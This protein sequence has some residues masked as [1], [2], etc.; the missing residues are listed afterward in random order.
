[1]K[2]NTKEF[3]IGVIIVAVLIVGGAV[4]IRDNGEISNQ[5]TGDFNIVDQATQGLTNEGLQ[6]ETTT[7]GTGVAAI[8]GDTVLVHYTGKL[9]DG[10]VFDSSVENGRSPI[11]FTLGQNKVIKG[12]EQGIVGMKVGEKRHLVIPPALAYGAAGLGSVPPNATLNFDVEL[13]EVV[14]PSDAAATPPS[15]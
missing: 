7:E 5:V 10:T 14:A 6:I 12:W 11:E 3:T 13:V 9:D 1:M 8:V 4:Y 2:I 15:K